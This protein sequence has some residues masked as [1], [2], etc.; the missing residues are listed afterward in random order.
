LHN[1]I[2][3]NRYEYFQHARPIM[4]FDYMV[5]GKTIIS[6][7]LAETAEIINRYRC[8]IIVNSYEKMGEAIEYLYRNPDIVYT[9]GKNGRKAVEEEFN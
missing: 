8:R 9:F 4:L 3:K 5:A 6:L 2:P 1:S 7:N